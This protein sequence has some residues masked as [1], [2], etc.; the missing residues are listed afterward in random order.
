MATKNP[1]CCPASRVKFFVIGLNEFFLPAGPIVLLYAQPR[2][3]LAGA[4]GK[5]IRSGRHITNGCI[6][7]W[8]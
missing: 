5:G 2:Y 3:M 8:H 7:S 1:A 4:R 6:Q